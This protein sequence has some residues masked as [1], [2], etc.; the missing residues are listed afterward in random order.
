[1]KLVYNKV[2]DIDAFTGGVSESSISD[3]VV[4]PTFGCILAKQFKNL[5]YGDRF[6]YTHKEDGIKKERGLSK[7]QRTQ[8]QSRKL[9]DIMCDNMDIESI[10][11]NVFQY[12]SELMS[13]SERKKLNL[14]NVQAKG[15]PDT[16]TQHGDMC[17]KFAGQKS[18]QS[19]K[20]VCKQE[21]GEKATLPSVKNSNENSF[22]A[23]TFTNEIIWL[24]AKRVSGTSFQWE[25]GSEWSYSNWIP[26][27]PNNH[28][29]HEDCIVTN[30]YKPGQGGW[31]DVD[32]NRL[33]NTV[34]QLPSGSSNPEDC[35]PGIFLNTLENVTR[36]LTKFYQ[37]GKHVNIA[38]I[39][40][41]ILQK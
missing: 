5:L 8:I 29:K 34:C 17:Y 27:E 10:N 35:R 22:L 23:K 31:N 13:C 2:D 36:E 24:G 19:A 16:W 21:G 28:N 14:T 7:T 33:Y 1:L 4:G 20:S 40:M 30:W 39:W 37:C 11:K 32:C 38:M 3:G 18:F 15:C 25:D 6:F 26:N 9:S 12:K 41:L